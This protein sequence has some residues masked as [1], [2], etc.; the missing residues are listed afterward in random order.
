MSNKGFSDIPAGK[1]D[2]DLVVIYET[3]DLS[4]LTVIKSIL[5]GGEIPYIVQGEAAL[6]LLPLR[7]QTVC[8]N[9]PPLCA[10]I[11]AP[12]ECVDEARALLEIAQIPAE[13]VE[14]TD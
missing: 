5:D 10:V 14:V 8:V 1:N 13:C 12:S 11:H 2:Q 3:A 9:K 6:G 7:E 4:L